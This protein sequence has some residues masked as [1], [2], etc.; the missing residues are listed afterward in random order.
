MA[1]LSK[2]GTYSWKARGAQVRDA[3]HEHG[4]PARAQHR[5]KKDTRRWCRGKPG[6]EHQ[7]VVTLSDV[8]GLPKL[9]QHCSSCGR[10]FGTHYAH[11][12]WSKAP[13]WA[14]AEQLAALERAKQ[15]TGVRRA[16]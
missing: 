1:T 5:S 13:G 16:G 3:R 11:S 14:S 8:R 15:L 12:I 4:G 10:E 9:V 7:L 6:V 2:D